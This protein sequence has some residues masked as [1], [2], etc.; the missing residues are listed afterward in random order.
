MKE[1]PKI[2]VIIPVYNAAPYLRECL[3]SVLNQT[4]VNLEI[5]LI[6]DGSTDGSGALC[7]AY[8]V[9]D[10]RVRVFH[11]ENRGQSAA[12][13]V[14][15]DA[16]TGDLIAFVDADDVAAPGMLEQLLAALNTGADFAICNIR[17][18]DEGGNT[19]DLCPI[20][21]GVLTREEFLDKLLEEQAWFYV[22]PGG[23]LYRRG[24]FQNLR[25]PEG[26]IYEDEAVLYSIVARCRQIATL[27]DGLYYYRQH[28][29]STMGQGLRIQS[30]DK[31]TAL[32][33]RLG[34]CR[35]MGWDTALEA[36]A[37]RF[38]HSFFDYYFRFPK[39]EET[40]PYFARMDAALKLA[41]LCILGAKSVAFRHK[42]YL[43]LVR[44]HPN[45]YVFLRK[46]KRK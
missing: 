20:G 12:R 31:L 46:W 25:F 39:N 14:G 27:S 32:A 11:Q 38:A 45:L 33:G 28:G 35:E 9:R 41:L 26:F 37:A 6:D 44:I 29:A 2:S 1:N 4:Y 36:N 8:A 43:I 19:L 17:R 42:L 34:L 7:D 30:T 21:D 23:K 16:M 24:I 3:D 22:M 10:G 13:N 18:I 15:L 5:M 40:K